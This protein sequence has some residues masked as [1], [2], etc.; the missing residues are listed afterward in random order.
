[1]IS[2]FGVEHG[3]VSK[4]LSMPKLPT[5]VTSGL[6]TIGQGAKTFG[7]GVGQGVKSFLPNSGAAMGRGVTNVGNKM[8]SNPMG[9]R[10]RSLGTTMAAH[11]MATGA[12]VLGGGSALGAGTALGRRQNRNGQ[13]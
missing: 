12:S 10:L 4:A 3:E 13:Y 11:P 8:G 9:G 1:M 7:T 5:G 6:K 2:A